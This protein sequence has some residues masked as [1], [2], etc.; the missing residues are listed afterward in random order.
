MTEILPSGSADERI[1]H[2]RARERR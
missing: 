2:C 1:L